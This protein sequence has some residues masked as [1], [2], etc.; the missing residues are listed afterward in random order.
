M[1]VFG[2]LVEYNDIRTLVLDLK[3]NS[4]VVGTWRRF[5]VI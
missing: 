2:V 4:S 1:A 3:N 5:P